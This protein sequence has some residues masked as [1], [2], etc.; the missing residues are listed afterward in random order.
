MP[1]NQAHLINP[2]LI[3]SHLQIA[4]IPAAH[5]DI[6]HAWQTSISRRSIYK[7]KETALHSHF[8]QKLLI[9][10]LGYQG[11]GGDVWTLAQEQT[12]GAGR[13][14]VALGEFSANSANIVAPFEL[15]GANTKDLDAIM[16]G[17]H[18]SPVQQAW[19][20]AMD[21]P[22]A[23]WVLVSNYLEIRLY[24][25][26]YGRQAYEVWDLSKLTDPVE[27]ARL[28]W[29]VS[30]K[31]L[32]SGET[33][34]ILEQS[35]QLEKEITHQLYKEYK[36]LRENLLHRLSADNPA[37]APLE[38][39]RYAQT[40]LDRILFIA[41]AEDRGLLPNKTIAQ[42]YQYNNP[43]NPRPVWENFKGLFRAIDQGSAALNILAYNGG[44]F[45]TDADL[46]SLAVSDEL[47]EAFKELADY[48]FDS[49]VSVTVLGHIFEQ[50]I[51]DIEGLQAEAT[52]S[53]SSVSKRKQHGVVYT[54]D[55][56]TRF[57][58]DKSLGGHLRAK[59]AELWNASANKRKKDGTW[60]KKGDPEIQFWRDYQRV[61]RTTRVVDPACGSGA[62]LV[63]AFDFLHDDYS[64]VNAVLADL[65]GSY[66]VFDLD[67]EI[68]NR[69]LYGVDV[70]S[71]SVEITKLSLWLK[72]AKRNKVL[73]SLD[74]NIQCGNSLINDPAYTDKPFAW[75]QR[76][77]P[78]ES[79]EGGNAESGF[80]VVLGNPP[81]VRQELISPIKPYLEQH[82]QVYNGVVDLYAYFFELGLKLLKPGGRLGYISSSTFFKTGSG[83]NLRRVLLDNASLE[84]VVDFG[85][86]QIF[87]GV[88]TYPAILTMRKAEPHAEHRLQTLVL[89]RD[90]PAD[91]EKHFSKHAV[92][93]SQTHL[94]VSAW[95]L[96]ND[97]LF[98]LRRKITANKPTLKEVYGSPL[99]GI[100]TGLNEAFVI[101]Q[102]TRDA[103]V[104]A[105]P[106][107]ADVLKPFLEGKDIKKW[108]VEPRSLW[109]IFTRRGIEIEN[110]PAVVDYLNHFRER[111]EPKPKDWPKEKSWKGRK[112]GS[113]QWYE[114]Q[115]TI[116]YYE[117]FE[118]TKIIWPNLQVKSKFMFDSSGFYINAPAV[119]LPSG[120]YFLVGLLNSSVTWFF[121]KNTAISRMQSFLEIK[122]V[123][124]KQIP[125]PNATETQ[126]QT[127]AQIAENCQTTA[128]IRYQ[129]QEAVRRRI[130]D[131]C[132]PER[133]A[134]LSTK[135][136][137]WWLLDFA[138]FRAE[139]KKT[140]KQDIPLAERNDW[141]HWLNTERT[142]IDKL[143]AQLTALEQE[144][145]AR[146]YA[147]FE[148]TDD[149]ISLVEENQ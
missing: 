113:Y 85:D 147:L 22:G 140:F 133:E 45:Q 62:F 41:F 119:I 98:A 6:L 50:S 51:T 135:L 148:L 7:Q 138:G 116:D 92:P 17:R 104:N 103:L 59:F 117:E 27:Y 29:L 16:P 107:S 54:P 28:Q 4:D 84:T 38:L 100:K 69:N 86:L 130:P 93:M 81:Y 44:L 72:T 15:K 43:Y 106:K 60:I 80:D 2:R 76:G 124:V 52:G 131:L 87:E 95:H 89:D 3:K 108:S 118:K 68:L 37:R 8:I 63:A 137:H 115:D 71:E 14:D 11:F 82:Y 67:K 94:D 57:I 129:K 78:L 48:D 36:T 96:E 12:I 111:L 145:N 42:A 20:Y 25:V 102:A 40:I 101:D 31:Q 134:K 121:L 143:S 75:S 24:A 77:W 13:V 123:Y 109:L 136:N 142:E 91:L 149:E 127:I 144:L 10:V 125:I 61:L 139:I 55:H 26:G 21:A 1:A 110:Y 83:E 141:E 128:E 88:T 120:D 30:A 35:E 49:E 58:V 64:R 19:E 53:V 74:A 56:I 33:R 105:D 5:L 66:D 90:I 114:I 32:L 97:V 126:K 47:C 132:P 122:P 73:N 79:G 18:K 46:E 9:E 65:T 70:N 99:Y 112:A 23:Q 146:V 34:K 39:I